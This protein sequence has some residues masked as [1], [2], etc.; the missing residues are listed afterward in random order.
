MTATLHVKTLAK[1]YTFFNGIIM[2]NSVHMIMVGHWTISDKFH[3][4]SVQKCVSADNLSA[5]FFLHST[6]CVDGE[7]LAMQTS[8]FLS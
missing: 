5:Q 6:R 1:N 3:C 8:S 4:V 7:S 2:Y